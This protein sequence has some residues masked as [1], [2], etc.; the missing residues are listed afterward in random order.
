MLAGTAL[1]SLDRDPPRH[2]PA[3]VLVPGAR[4]PRPRD[5]RRLRLRRR[6]PA[7]QRLDAGDGP[8]ER[9]RPRPHRALDLP[10]RAPTG[11]W[12]PSSAATSPRLDPGAPA[13][14][15]RR[16]PAADPRCAADRGRGA[17]ALRREVALALTT[18]ALD[19]DPARGDRRQRPRRPH[20]ERAARP[21][22]ALVSRRDRGLGGGDRDRRPER[23]DHL[24]E[25]GRRGDVRPPRDRGGGKAAD[26]PDARALPRGP[27][28][29]PAT[30]P[31]DA[32][33][34]R[35]RRDDRGLRRPFQRRGV[36]D[37]ALA[38]RLGGRG[39][40]PLHRHDPRHQQAPRRRPRPARARRDR[41]RHLRRGDRLG[42]RRDRHQLEPRR[43]AHLRLQR[44]GDGRPPARRA[45]RRPGASPSCRSCSSGSGRASGSRTSRPCGCART[46][47][48]S[49]SR[50]PFRRSA[51]RPA[52]S[53]A[54]RRSP[55]TSP[56]RRRPSAGSPR[57]PG[58]S[59]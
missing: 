13:G 43:R 52:W 32:G 55:A 58:T 28:R 23:P 51:T 37:F 44:R 3:T 41:R 7:R 39:T 16:P 14:A 29:R 10:L 6:L 40:D 5:A 42:P 12:S 30:A 31:R 2:R 45:R 22:R 17:R 57:A 50:S 15:A 1:V 20:P 27:P 54:S 35:D 4:L 25:P 34:A 9:D 21:Q 49:T 38:R 18:L 59:S 48:G 47:A 33:A 11:A 56:S 53:P 36:S 46:G 24:S 8:A 19:P 26:D